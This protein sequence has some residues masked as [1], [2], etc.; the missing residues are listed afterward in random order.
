MVN[1]WKKAERLLQTPGSICDAPEMSNA[2]CV[3]SESGG[4]PQIIYTNKKG[5]ICYDDACIYRMEIT[6]D[7]C[8]CGCCS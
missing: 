6:K 7:L 2:K 4:K 3:A 1:I 5:T 8:S